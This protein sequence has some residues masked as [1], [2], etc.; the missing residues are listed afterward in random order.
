[1]YSSFCMHMFAFLHVSLLLFFPGVYSAISI[2][3]ITCSIVGKIAA[4]LLMLNVQCN[5]NFEDSNTLR[6]LSCN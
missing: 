1:M 5:D 4:T 3:G 6:I 2:L